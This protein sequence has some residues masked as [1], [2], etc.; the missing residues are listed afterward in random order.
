MEHV[1]AR[2]CWL[3][4]RPQGP[5]VW[6]VV[7]LT[8][9]RTNETK[10]KEPRILPVWNMFWQEIVDWVPGPRAPE[11]DS[12]ITWIWNDQLKKNAIIHSVRYMFWKVLVRGPTPQIWWTFTWIWNEHLKQIHISFCLA[13][14]SVGFWQQIW[15]TSKIIGNRKLTK[16]RE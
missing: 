1:L 8:L 7:Y 15:F 16:G 13:Y 3:G 12:L 9:K 2:N 10:K 14:V 4:P 6:F 11:F 5:R